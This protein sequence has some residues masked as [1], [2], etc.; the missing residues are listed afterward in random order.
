MAK[1]TEPRV[2]AELGRPETP[3]ET[4]A[5]KAEQSRLYRDR[6]TLRNLLYA[7]LVSVGLVAAIILLVPR[8][9]ESLL[10]CV[11]YQEVAA[12]AQSS[13][14]VPLAAPE[15]PGGWQSNA[16]EVRSGTADGVLSWYVGLITP[17]K[18][19]VGL[20]Q[21]VDANPTWLADQ[22]AR[23]LAS[24]TVA[25]DGVDW[26]IYDN[27]DRAGSSDSVGNAEYALT[28]ESGATTYVVFGT[29]EPD[30]IQQVAAALAAN[31][32][33]QPAEAQR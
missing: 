4:A 12:N 17:S 16:A 13:M 24:G 33:E 2:V 20:T 29:A 18:Q 21:A 14:P 6:K 1:S 30:E 25:L 31:V 11:D 7:L 26:T 9:E 5:R 23:G 19:Y 8:P 3:D 27:R 28:A 15:L 22:V 32:K 10:Q